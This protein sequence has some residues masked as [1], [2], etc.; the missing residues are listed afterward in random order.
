MKLTGVYDSVTLL[1]V[2][3]DNYGY[4]YLEGTSLSENGAYLIHPLNW[5]KSD[6]ES[7]K[8]CWPAMERAGLQFVGLPEPIQITKGQTVSYYDGLLNGKKCDLKFL[9]SKSSNPYESISAK[10][11]KA[12]KQ[13][14]EI[15]II[16]IDN[17]FTDSELKSL[18]GRVKGKMD[19]LNY[20]NLKEVILIK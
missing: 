12:S 1:K 8:K 7:A 11:K 9:E 3:F 20:T 6:I 4:V 10:M 19:N 17:S 16:V 18:R 2:L 15:V 13:G 14:A 5:P